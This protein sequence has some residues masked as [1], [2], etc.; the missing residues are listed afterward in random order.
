MDYY[1]RLETRDPA[2]RERDLM[3]GLP[4]QIAYAKAQSPYFAAAF[5]GVDAREVTTR[6]AL[7]RLPVIRKS[8]LIALQ[9]QLGPFGGLT[10]T[11]LGQLS[12]L[13]CSPGPIHDP[14]GCGED[15]WRSARALFGAGFRAGDLIHNTFSYHFTPGGFIV[16][17]GARKLGCPVFPAGTGNVEQQISVIASLRPAGFTG[18]PSFLKII[19]DKAEERGADIGSLRKAL[20]SSEALPPSLR[21]SFEAR[22]IHVRQCYVTAD[23]GTLAYE[24]EA[25]EGMILDEHVLIEIVQP[26][27]GNPVSEGEVGE[28]IV[29]TFNRDYPLIRFGTGDLSAVLPGMSPCGRTNTRIK[30]W[31]GRADQTA[32]FKGLFVHPGEVAEVLRRHPEVRKGRLT[33]DNSAGEDRMTLHCEVADG[34]ETLKK[35]IVASI[36]D[37][38]TMRGEVNFREPESLPNDGKLI[39]DLRSYQ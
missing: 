36:R 2:E 24:S 35:A 4:E 6:E 11:P 15:W 19:L 23:A 10:A 26:G 18:T 38:T 29:T 7:A 8:E 39:E 37:V 20:V 16:D 17:S 3:T 14:E 12:R 13:Y 25:M 5:A 34:S 21:T 22:G 32:K 27:T 1:D 30:G 31:M 33:I 9:Q 28:V